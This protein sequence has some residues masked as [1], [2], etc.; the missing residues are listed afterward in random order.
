MKKVY[1]IYILSLCAMIS[2]WSCTQE[3][4]DVFD[5]SAPERLEGAANE[6]SQ[7]LSSSSL[8]WSVNYYPDVAYTG[9]YNYL[10]RFD[11]TKVTMRGDQHSGDAYFIAIGDDE[12]SSYYSINKSQGVVLSFDT[13]NIIS[14]LSDP[15]LFYYGDGLNGDNEFVWRKT[16]ENND[17]IYFTGKKR[18]EESAKDSIPS[19]NIVFVRNQGDWNNYFDKIK[20]HASAFRTGDMNRYFKQV[21]LQDGSSLLLAGYST[22]DRTVYSMA[23]SGVKDSI[24]TNSSLG[25][26]FTQE[27]MEFYKALDVQGKSVRKFSLDNNTGKFI[28][29]EPG[30]SGEL[31][32]ISE[33]SFIFN[34]TNDSI[35]QT[36]KYYLY[37]DYSPEMNSLYQKMKEKLPSFS[38]IC[39]GIAQTSNDAHALIFM[40]GGEDNVSNIAAWVPL[41]YTKSTTRGDKIKFIQPRSVPVTGT[42]ASLLKDE[43]VAFSKLLTDDSNGQEYIIIPNATYSRYTLGSCSTGNYFTVR[44][45]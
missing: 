23:E 16:S 37:T 21:T 13:Y 8:G 32:G 34:G 41:N 33:P 43:C 44:K 1:Y 2:M 22:L 15:T 25:L 38:G 27:G 31:K 11:G 6:L 39:W 10:M 26:S 12:S 35:L 18:D 42:Y 30:M 28:V 3:E 7:L 9:G 29:N 14:Q 17:T 20:T 19:A 5:K 4:D 45:W 40:Y 24:I 36:R